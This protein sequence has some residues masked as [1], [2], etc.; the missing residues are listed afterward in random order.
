MYVGSNSGLSMAI[1]S[2]RLLELLDSD[3][4]AESIRLA[5][6]D[7]KRQ[8]EMRSWLVDPP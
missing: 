1:P 4:M 7:P 5:E 8:A 2:W 3:A 6:T